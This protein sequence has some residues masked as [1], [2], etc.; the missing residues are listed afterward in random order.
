VVLV[1]FVV[2]L[3]CGVV[4]VV[5]RSVG[6]S[7]LVHVGYNGIQMIAALVYTHGFRHMEKAVVV[8]PFS[9]LFR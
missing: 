8:I 1:I 5:T 6:A 2:G 3:I 7:F 4:R 9:V